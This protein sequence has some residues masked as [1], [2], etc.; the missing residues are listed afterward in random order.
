MGK[1]EVMGLINSGNE[2]GTQVNCYYRHS[3]CTTVSLV[4][5]ISVLLVA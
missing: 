1:A 2:G 3:K 5:V 4:A